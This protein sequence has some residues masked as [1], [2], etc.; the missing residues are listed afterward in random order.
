MCLMLLKQ[1]EDVGMYREGK[2]TEM[3]INVKACP[4][5]ISLKEGKEWK[6]W[7]I[8]HKKGEGSQDKGRVWDEIMEFK[9]NPKTPWCLIGDFN[10]IRAQEEKQGGNPAAIRRLQQFYEAVAG[11]EVLDIESSGDPFTWCNN[12]RQ[13]NV[14]KQRLDRG[15][16][17]GGWSEIFQGLGLY[18]SWQSME[19][20]EE[21][22]AGMWER[23][24]DTGDNLNNCAKSLRRWKNETI[25]ENRVT[26]ADLKRDLEFLSSLPYNQAVY[27]QMDMK[28][29]ELIRHWQVE[30]EY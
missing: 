26:I 6:L 13:G 20:Y 22:V 30:E 17:N 4:S 25:G 23:G 9:R 29:K 27:E 16:C 24:R 5:L 7:E 8:L 18:M 28:Q 19:G 14:I 10:S 11:W 2:V 12:N 1:L 3:R 21:I 15:L